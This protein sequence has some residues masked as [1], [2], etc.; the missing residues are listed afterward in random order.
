MPLKLSDGS[1]RCFL[2]SG[3]MC[4]TA[5]EREAPVWDHQPS[6]KGVQSAAGHAS[7]P[8]GKHRST[9]PEDI[10]KSNITFFDYRVDGT[11]WEHTVFTEQHSPGFLF[12]VNIFFF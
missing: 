7:R 11:I 4:H 1:V 8:A 9:A 10:R 3:Q 5:V 6:L 2:T 12:K